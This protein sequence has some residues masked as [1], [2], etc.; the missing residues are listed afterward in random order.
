MQDSAGL[1]NVKFKIGA[2]AVLAILVAWFGWGFYSNYTSV[3]KASADTGAPPDATSTVPATTNAPTAST[4]TDATTNVADA[5]TNGAV[6]TTTN[7]AD[8]TDTNTVATVTNAEPAKSPPSTKPAASI[9]SQRGSMIG[10]LIALIVAAI[11]LGVMVAYDA[12]QYFSGQAVDFLFEGKAEAERDPEYEKAEQVWANGKH[13]E[14]IQ[15]MRD[16]LKTHPREQYVAL[17]IAEIYEKDLHNY[18]AAAL[19]NEEVLK[20]KLT[21]DRWGWTAIHLCNLYSKLGQQDKTRALLQRIVTEYPQTAAAKKARSRLGLVELE[22]EAEPVAPDEGNIS[23]EVAPYV[24][25][26]PPPPS[27]SN[28]PPGFRPKK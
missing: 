11:C 24:E 1:M 16:Y 22:L 28:L 25:E 18:L 4:N 26:A 13:L 21:P 17:R 12:T 27:D 5:T 19:E 20:Q 7:A 14:A 8:Q 15:L 3:T 9:E 6:A 2:Y 10:Y 23:E